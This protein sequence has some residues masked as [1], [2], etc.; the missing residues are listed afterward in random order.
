MNV[1]EILCERIGWALLILNKVQWQA[2]VSTAPHEAGNFLRTERLS[3]SEKGLCALPL[4][5]N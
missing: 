4:V 5:I 3:A 2:L 1:E